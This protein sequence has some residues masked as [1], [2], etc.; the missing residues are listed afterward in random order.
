MNFAIVANAYTGSD[1]AILA[2]GA[3]FPDL[4]IFHDVA[5]MPNRSAITNFCGWIDA[6]SLVN[7]WHWRGKMCRGGEEVLFLVQM[8]L[9]GFEGMEHC[10]C[11]LTIGEG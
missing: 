8:G 10:E 2:E 1:K 6:G 9:N 3:I 11:T 4:S 5:E 7:C